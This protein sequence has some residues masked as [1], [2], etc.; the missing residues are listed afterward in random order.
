MTTVATITITLPIDEEITDD[1]RNAL[2]QLAAVM[3]VQAE[4]GLWT[5]GSPEAEQDE[6]I[7]EHLLNFDGA[8]YAV[9]VGPRPLD[10]L[11]E[12]LLT[13]GR[14]AWGDSNDDEIEALNDALDQ[15]LSLLGVTRPEVDEPEEED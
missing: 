14:A 13:S 4:D 10:A 15:A 3:L 2:D 5:L 12:A 6:F 1:V 11:T 9:T 7:N 8:D